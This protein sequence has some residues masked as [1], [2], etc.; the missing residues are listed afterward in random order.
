MSYKK[1]IVQDDRD[2][3]QTNLHEGIHGASLHRD[4]TAHFFRWCF[5]RRLITTSNDVLEIGCGKEQPLFRIIHSGSRPGG[6]SKT[7]TGVDLNKIAR[8]NRPHITFH[9][10][11]NFVERHQELIN[12]KP[13]LYDRVVHFEVLEHMR[14]DHGQQ[15]LQNCYDVCRP[16]GQM[17]MSTPVFDGKRHAANHIH[18]YTLPELQK[19]IEDAGFKITKRFGTF[20]DIRH[21]GKVSTGDQVLDDAVK[22]LYPKLAEYFENDA[23]SNIFANMYP[24]HARNNVWICEK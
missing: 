19:C 1:V 24:D 4:Y 18:E 22:I 7:Y 14:Y 15:F 20:M 5:A 13:E 21:I 10:E 17:I 11:F 3:D 6:Y 2:Y 12:A 9:G 16:G 23:V 8:K